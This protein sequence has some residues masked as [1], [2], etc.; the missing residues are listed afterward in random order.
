MPVK[1][2][3]NPTP[4]SIRE[5]TSIRKESEQCIETSRLAYAKILAKVA[6]IKNG[7]Q[8]T[9][10]LANTNTGTTTCAAKLGRKATPTADRLES[11][12]SE[13]KGIST[14][15]N[16]RYVQRVPRHSNTDESRSKLC[17]EGRANTQSKQESSDRTSMARVQGGKNESHG[18]ARN[19]AQLTADK[20]PK[21]EA[22][23]QQKEIAAKS[24]AKPKAEKR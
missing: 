4:M 13:A 17:Q 6:S 14:A 5:L 24:K 20:K 15:Q 1:H 8:R 12:T 22:K 9:L 16:R 7:Q 11:H 2:Q 10:D 18:T 19:Q 23:Q 3:P 21:P